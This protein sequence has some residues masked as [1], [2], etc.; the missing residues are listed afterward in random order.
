MKTKHTLLSLALAAGLATA[1]HA[2][3]LYNSEDYSFTAGNLVGQDGW[4]AHSGAGNLPV[5]VTSGGVV[6]L[7][8]GSGSRE[9]VN[10]N[11]GEFTA[12]NTYYAGFILSNSGVIPMCISPIS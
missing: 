10:Q 8:Q 1:A 2:Q 11:V 4:A 6:T 3:I 12:G 7:A 5:Q 9:D